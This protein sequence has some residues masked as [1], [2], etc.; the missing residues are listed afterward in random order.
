M[1]DTSCGG[2]TAHLRDLCVS[3]DLDRV[4]AVG[5]VDDDAVGLAVA[6]GS[7]EGA[8]ELDVQTADVGSAQ[9]VDGDDVRA[10]EGVEVDP[11]DSGGV[12]RDVALR[13]EELEPVSVRRQ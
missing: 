10:A 1:K 4:V 9:V 5:G 8:C 7:A 12:H 2:K 6:R 3:A 13:T 11:L